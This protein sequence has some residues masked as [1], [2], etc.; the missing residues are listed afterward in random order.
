MD[1]FNQW[2]LLQ[3]LNPSSPLLMDECLVDYLQEL[4]DD[5]TGVNDGVRARAAVRFFLPALGTSL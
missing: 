2:L 5:G 3:D 4:F 1:M